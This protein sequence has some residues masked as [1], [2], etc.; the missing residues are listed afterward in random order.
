MGISRHNLYPPP[1]RALRAVEQHRLKWSLVFRGVSRCCTR[2]SKTLS[3]NHVN[4]KLN[5]VLL[6][7][8]RN[9]ILQWIVFK[10][11]TCTCDPQPGGG[12]TEENLTRSRD[13]SC[14]TECT[15][16][17]VISVSINCLIADSLLPLNRK[18]NSFRES[19]FMACWSVIVGDI[20]P[21]QQ[22]PR[23]LHPLCGR[24]RTSE[25]Q[26]A[27]CSSLSS[28][29]MC[30]HL[31]EP[32]FHL[33]AKWIIYDQCV[34][35][36]S[37]SINQPWKHFTGRDQF[38]ILSTARRGRKTRSGGRGAGGLVIKRFGDPWKS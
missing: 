33:F 2:S 32:D 37:C 17:D 27:S 29:T 13:N 1:H 19:K 35:L 3:Q 6:L 26:F 8:P 16:D 38:I 5:Q 36:F 20:K 21:H 22:P 10:V 4:K 23:R 18:I 28:S 34:W 24:R 31:A 30:D 11:T 14:Y 12:G 15:H 25:P 7:H 9:V